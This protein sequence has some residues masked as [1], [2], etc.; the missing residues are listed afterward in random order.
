MV[1]RS[2]Y[3]QLRRPA[4]DIYAALYNHEKV[5]SI[6]N[7]ELALAQTIVDWV[8]GFPYERNFQDS[9][10]AP[11]SAVLAGQSGSDCDSRSILLAILLHHMNYQTVMFLSPAYQHAMLGVEVETI[12]AKMKVNDKTFMVTETTDQVA[13]GQ[14][15]ASMSVEA[16]WLPVTFP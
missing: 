16:N 6:E 5:V 1:Y 4:F 2:A 13:I 3:Q 12:G 14:V 9:D 10:F 11:I 7:K 8:Q 15:A